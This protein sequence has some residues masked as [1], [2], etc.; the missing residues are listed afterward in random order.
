MLEENF[1]FQMRHGVGVFAV[2]SLNK[3]A[4]EEP[5]LAHSLLVERHDGTFQ[6]GVHS[7]LA[8][9]YGAE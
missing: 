2:Y 7:P 4:R 5:Y 1:Y 8:K 6:I 3:L 9:P